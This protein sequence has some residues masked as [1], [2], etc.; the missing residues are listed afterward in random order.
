MSNDR[1]KELLALVDRAASPLLRA[2]GFSGPDEMYSTPHYT[3]IY[4]CLQTIGVEFYI[5]DKDNEVSCYINRLSAGKP[6]NSFRLDDNGDLARVMLFE[7]IKAKNLPFIGKTVASTSRDASSRIRMDNFI[8]CIE[9][10]VPEI[11]NDDT[12]IFDLVK[13]H[14]PCWKRRW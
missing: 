8:V 5:E 14:D 13:K 10:Q 2:H 7:I 4:Y 3:K 1:T 11:L 6:P 12:S 9:M